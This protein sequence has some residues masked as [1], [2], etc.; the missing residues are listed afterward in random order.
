M[1]NLDE[2]II[3]ELSQQNEFVK[4]SD[5][6]KKFTDP[7]FPG[8][9]SFLITTQEALI[10]GWDKSR[11]EYPEE[12]RMISRIQAQCYRGERGFVMGDIEESHEDMETKEPLLVYKPNLQKILKQ[13]VNRPL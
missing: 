2:K 11:S 6:R 3:E 7:N 10:V 9:L 4:Y 1:D 5:L 12:A 8:R 13:Q